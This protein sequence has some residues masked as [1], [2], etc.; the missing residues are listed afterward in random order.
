MRDDFTAASTAP[1]RGNAPAAQSI[2]A[3][4]LKIQ[5][6]CTMIFFGM[7]RVYDSY[8]CWFCHDSG[9][10]T[11]L[12]FVEQSW[13]AVQSPLITSAKEASS[14]TVTAELT[15]DAAFSITREHFISLIKFL[16][17][18]TQCSTEVMLSH[19]YRLI[20]VIIKCKSVMINDTAGVIHI[21]KIHTVSTQQKQNP[22]IFASCS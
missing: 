13:A 1:L 7:S 9:A 8:L 10:C 3:W 4:V 15:E 6:S 19:P 5:I 11:D 20:I 18:P 21:N 16:L 17:F 22:F 2:W 12:W 14:A